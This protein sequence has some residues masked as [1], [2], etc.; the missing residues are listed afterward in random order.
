MKHKTAAWGGMAALLAL[1]AGGTTWWLSTAPPSRPN[2]PLDIVGNPRIFMPCAWCQAE[3]DYADWYTKRVEQ[4]ER[5]SKGIHYFIAPPGVEPRRQTS[6][7]TVSYQIWQAGLWEAYQIALA[8]LE[9][10][11]G[12]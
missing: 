1:F 8:K 12:P 4:G 10:D 3:Q 6:E 7:G 5:S 11:A 2:I 9:Q